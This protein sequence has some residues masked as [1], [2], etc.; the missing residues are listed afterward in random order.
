MWG[1]EL[2][3]LSIAG[4]RQPVNYRDPHVFFADL[5]PSRETIVQ[6][7]G[8]AFHGSGAGPQER[9]QLK[10]EPFGTGLHHVIQP[11]LR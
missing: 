7:V 8:R 3:T 6:V 4:C 11:S 5:I 1:K 9:K 2:G 10:R